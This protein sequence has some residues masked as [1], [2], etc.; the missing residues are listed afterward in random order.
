MELREDWY[1]PRLMGIVSN[2]VVLPGARA[3]KKLAVAVL[4]PPLLIVEF[5]RSADNDE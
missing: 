5:P 2:L 4:H 1:Q 3:P